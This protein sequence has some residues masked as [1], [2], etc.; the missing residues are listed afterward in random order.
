[1]KKNYIH[2]TNERS[3]PK[4]N[5]HNSLCMVQD[6]IECKPL[7]N[8]WL[9]PC[10]A[11]AV[12]PSVIKVHIRTPVMLES[13]FVNINRSLKG[14]KAGWNWKSLIKSTCLNQIEITWYI[15]CIYL[16]CYFQIWC[17]R[18]M[19]NYIYLLSVWEY[20]PQTNS[21]NLDDAIKL[22]SANSKGLTIRFSP[23]A[24][25]C[26]AHAILFR[27]VAIW[28]TCFSL[29]CYTHGPCSWDRDRLTFLM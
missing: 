26:L 25:A 12:F 22:L 10:S 28:L 6:Q 5:Y 2:P 21:V 9:P 18:D 7:Q 23:Y 19:N 14:N 8:Y 11:F 24:I 4:L 1:M 15:Y 16:R 29:V 3:R 20:P 17:K 27:N 13:K